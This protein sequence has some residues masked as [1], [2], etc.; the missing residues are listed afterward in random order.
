MNFD[1]LP[2]ARTSS[3]DWS[4]SRNHGRQSWDGIYF[5]DGYDVLV[6]PGFLHALALLVLGVAVIHDSAN[7]RH[8]VRRH[9]HQVQPP[10]KCVLQRIWGASFPVDFL[11]LVNSCAL[12]V[13][14]CPC[15][16]APSGRLACEC[17]NITLLVIRRVSVYY[18]LNHGIR[19]Q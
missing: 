3:R 17:R 16:L 8:R 7:A 2:S 1:L 13:R 6:L 5:L 18:V 10:L 4:C 11:G 15:S 9:F 14:L 19:D 12:C